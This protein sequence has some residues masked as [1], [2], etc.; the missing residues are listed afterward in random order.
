VALFAL[1]MGHEPDAAGV[2]LVFGRIK[3]MGLE[4][5]NFGSRR[6]GSL[7]SIQRD[8]EHS[9]VQQRCQAEYLGSGLIK[10]HHK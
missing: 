7:L 3:A 10:L 5:G 9:A 8:W 1:D 4:M 6:H 2:V